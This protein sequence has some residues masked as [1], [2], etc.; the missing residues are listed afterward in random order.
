MMN[1]SP[2]PSFRY[3]KL[4]LF[5]YFSIAVV[6]MVVAFVLADIVGAVRRGD[7]LHALV[8]LWLAAV[9]VMETSMLAFRRSGS[10]KPL[11]EMVLAG[12][13]DEHRASP[14]AS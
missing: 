12:D 9:V 11:H 1:R 4:I 5:I 3:I 7:N 8:D 2:L 6:E 14:T 10:G 13:P